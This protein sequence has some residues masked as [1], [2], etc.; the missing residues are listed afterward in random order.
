MLIAEIYNLYLCGSQ[1]LR[2]KDFIIISH[3][4]HDA[5]PPFLF[6]YSAA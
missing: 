4:I 5:L 1:L 6:I 3:E 2:T